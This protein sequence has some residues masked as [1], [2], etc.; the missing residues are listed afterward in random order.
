M[1]HKLDTVNKTNFIIAAN[2]LM[3]CVNYDSKRLFRISKFFS[4][5]LRQA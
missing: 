3:L 2:Y 5:I 4:K 1:D